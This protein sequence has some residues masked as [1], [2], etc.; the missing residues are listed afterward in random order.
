M[1]STCKICSRLK[2]EHTVSELLD[3][4]IRFVNSTY[5]MKK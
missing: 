4:A 2:S 1:T 5:T 3:C